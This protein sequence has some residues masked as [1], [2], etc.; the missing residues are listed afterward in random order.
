[1]DMEEKEMKDCD[2]NQAQTL[3][4]ESL[5]GTDED[6]SVAQCVAHLTH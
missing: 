6:C 4:C 3:C 1:M 2:S 5:E